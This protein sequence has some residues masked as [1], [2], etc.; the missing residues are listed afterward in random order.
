MSDAHV[1]IIGWGSLIWDLDDLAP[2]VVGPWRRGVG[3][4]LSVEFS[5]VSP[6][7]LGAL[8]LVI[9]PE[10]GQARPT[11][12]IVSAKTDVSAA[13]RDL[14]AR[15]RA[16]PASI[17]WV[18]VIEDAGQS[19][20]PGVAEAVADWCRAEG[21]KG[22]VWTDLAPN[23]SDAVGEVFSISAA[24]AYLET[25]SGAALIEAVRYVECAPRETDTPLRRALREDPWWRDLAGRLAAETP[26]DA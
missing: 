1:A 13:H 18:D 11:S 8:A 14:A 7:R 2:K 21:W 12:V 9:D 6:K 24:R 26:S 23:F 19:R 17:G 20:A 3:P 22:A 25:L 15:E 4:A 5:R 16:A 10:N